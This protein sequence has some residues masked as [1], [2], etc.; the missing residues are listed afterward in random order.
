MLRLD[1]RTAAHPLHERR[2]DWI[3]DAG[4]ANQWNS[5]GQHRARVQP[6]GKRIL[7]LS[8]EA[9]THDGC[10]VSSTTLLWSS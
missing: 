4:A 7:S 9:W 2:A 5:D 8:S 10:A 6:F 1:S 3:V